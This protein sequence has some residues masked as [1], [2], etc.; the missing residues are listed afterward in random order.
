L[1]TDEIARQCRQ[2]IKLIFSRAILDHHVLALDVAGILE[3]LSDTFMRSVSASDVA[4]ESIPTTG[5][6][7]CCALAA[8]GHAAAVPINVMKSRRL[9]ATLEG[10]GIWHRSDL[11]R[12]TG[13]G[14]CPLWVDAVEKGLVILGE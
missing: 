14:R 6:V 3:T 12:H 11:S 7:R 2:S 5:I 10:W 1:A 8:S 9:I 4:G 13:R